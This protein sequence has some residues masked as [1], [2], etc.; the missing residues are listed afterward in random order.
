MLLVFE[1]MQS[2]GRPTSR[3]VFRAVQNVYKQSTAGSIA[4]YSRFTN[5]S[6]IWT[7]SDCRLGQRTV[8]GKIIGNI[9]GLQRRQFAR[10]TSLRQDEKPEGPKPTTPSPT[11]PIPAEKPEPPQTPASTSTSLPSHKESQ[12]WDFSKRYARLLD[13]LLAQASIASHYINSY[14]GTD[15]SGI[16]ALRREITEKESETKDLHKSVEDARTSYT[17]TFASQ[18]TAQK[19]I[20]SLLE[21]KNN[22]AGSDLERYM[23]LVRSEHLNDQAVQTAKDNLA[24][25]ERDL[26]SARVVLERLERKQYHEEQIWSDTIRRN[27]TWVTIGL[28]GLNI[29]LLLAQISVFEPYRRRKIV[30]QVKE[31]LDERALPATVV[32]AAAAAPEEVEEVEKQI[33]RVVPPAVTA[34]AAET[35]LPQ[36]MEQS[37]AQPLDAVLPEQ[38]DAGPTPLAAGEL[39]PEEAV[40]VQSAVFAGEETSAT[41]PEQFSQ[42][43]HEPETAREKIEVYKEHVRDLFSERVVQLKMVEVTTVA[44]QGAA[45][46]VA[47]MGLLFVLL[48]PR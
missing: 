2:V 25:A 13:R 44:L 12:R 19:E 18:A 47:A 20:V 38:E 15:Y 26:E 28:M 41:L 43:A 39:L 17:A 45:T 7:C 22:W 23:S 37:S 14:T 8:N 36:E 32:P 42:P 29:F 1:R 34:E 5:S 9:R 48:R 33:D 35:V 46:G 10:S 31:A 16:E 27:S 21:R 30:R 6:Q 40:H 11:Q 3:L 4:R 24:L